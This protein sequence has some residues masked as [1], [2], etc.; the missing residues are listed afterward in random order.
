MLVAVTPGAVAPPPLLELPP[1]ELELELDDPHAATASAAATA[2]A[3]PATLTFILSSS[4]W[5]SVTRWLESR[6]E[7]RSATRASPRS[8]PRRRPPPADCPRRCVRAKASGR[9]RSSS[10]ARTPAARRPRLHRPVSRGH[11]RPPR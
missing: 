4:C 9:G 7:S 5:L 8:E 3:D 1:P 2:K 10:S 6:L 11:P